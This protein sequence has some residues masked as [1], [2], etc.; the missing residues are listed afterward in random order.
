MIS[1]LQVSIFYPLP[2]NLLQLARH[3]TDSWKL[4]F[5]PS[6]DIPSSISSFPNQSSLKNW[7]ESPSEKWDHGGKKLGRIFSCRFN[8]Q[9]SNP[10][11]RIFDLKSTLR[12]SREH[13]KGQ[14]EVPWGPSEASSV[15]NNS[16]VRDLMALPLFA[17]VALTSDGSNL[18]PQ[19]SFP[20]WCGSQLGRCC[21]SNDMPLTKPSMP[22]NWLLLM[23]WHP[24][25]RT[26]T[27]LFSGSDWRQWWTMT[28]TTQPLQ[29]MIRTSIRCQFR[30]KAMT[31]PSNQPVC[32]ESKIATEEDFKYVV[33]H[34]QNFA[35]SDVEYTVKVSLISLECC[36]S[37]YL[38]IP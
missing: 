33:G 24:E 1:I 36:Y 13:I 17:T 30:S 15:W 10:L 16:N 26:L 11:S 14:I 6:I 22:S 5:C 12:A 8:Y 32:L 9:S 2:L 18:K 4:E 20:F 25:I 28:R 34:D 3:Q 38:P 29:N 35:S 27:R 37:G 23:E 31:E 7:F 19:L 21:W